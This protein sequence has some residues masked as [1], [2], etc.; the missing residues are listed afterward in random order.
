M[1]L[2]NKKPNAPPLSSQQVRSLLS[3]ATVDMNYSAVQDLH[4]IYAAM[5][6]PDQLWTWWLDRV[7]ETARAGDQPLAAMAMDFARKANVQPWGPLSHEHYE[8]MRLISPP[9]ST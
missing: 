8:R 6:P 7:E 9:A 5:A 3:M 4:R 2:F 1:G